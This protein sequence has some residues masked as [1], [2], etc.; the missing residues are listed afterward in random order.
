VPGGDGV[1]NG[2]RGDESGGNESEG[3]EL[4]VEWKDREG[5]E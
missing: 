3:G 1:G 5:I 2:G 4:H